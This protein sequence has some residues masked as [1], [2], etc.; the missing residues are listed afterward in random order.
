M[1]KY[2]IE[3][4][5]VMNMIVEVWGK[6]KPEKE[7]PYHNAN[8]ATDVLQTAYWLLEEG[9]LDGTLDTLSTF[10]LLL[11]A[12]IHD[13]EHP[14]RNNAFHQNTNSEWAM[15]YNDQSINE[16]GHLSS[17]FRL[18]SSDRCNIFSRMQLSERRRLR[19]QVRPSHAAPA[20]TP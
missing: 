13:M 18:V 5:T 15:T 14:G 11:G 16:N 4:G 17:F 6:Y 12:L 20:T 9:G 7:V 1:E 8:H 19:K 3:L 10:S 2:H